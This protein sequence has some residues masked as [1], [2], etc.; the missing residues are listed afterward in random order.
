MIDESPFADLMAQVEERLA[1]VPEGDGMDPLDAA[2]V[3][4]AVSVSVTCLDSEAIDEAV[5]AALE[6]GATAAQVQEVVALV[7]GLGVHSIMASATVVLQRAAERGLVDPAA[8]LDE[9]RRALWDRFVGDD[10]YWD[11]FSRH[12]PG[13][14]DAILCL[15]PDIFSGFFAYC[16]IP[17]KSGTVPAL[18]KELAA[19][20]CDVTPT[21]LFLPGVRLHLQNAIGL[22][23]TRTVV[24]QA[25]AIGTQARAAAMIR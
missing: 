5:V 3:R 14:L 18:T 8:P 7:S 21:H 19:I 15:S 6:S 10:P 9:E 2:L 23:A 20:A 16:A 24:R 25:I 13:F 11:A 1:D 12:V 22:G 4:L 17:W